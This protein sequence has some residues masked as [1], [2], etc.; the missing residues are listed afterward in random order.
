M[1]EFV[2]LASFDFDQQRRGLG[3]ADDVV[4]DAPDGIWARPVG[5]DDS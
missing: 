4:D 3:G 1:I 5:T 2:E